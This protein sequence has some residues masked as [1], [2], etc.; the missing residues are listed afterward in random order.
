[1][2]GGRVFYCRLDY[3]ASDGR[4]VDESERR[5]WSWSVETL[6]W[7]LRGETGEKEI[8]IKYL[9]NTDLE[10]YRYINLLRM[11]SKTGVR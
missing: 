5:K 9:P 3:I 11:K 2:W 6:S 1:V 4:N 7:N 10:L 8:R